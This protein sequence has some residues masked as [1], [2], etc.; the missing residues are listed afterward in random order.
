MVK[1]CPVVVKTCPV[2]IKRVPVVVKRFLTCENAFLTTSPLPN[3][4]VNALLTKLTFLLKT[5]FMAKTDISGENPV[6]G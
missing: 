1:T 6:Y 5:P 4:C 2:V 3:T